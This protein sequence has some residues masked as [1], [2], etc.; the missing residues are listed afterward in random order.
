MWMHSLEPMDRAFRVCVPKRCKKVP[1]DSEASDEKLEMRR[2]IA[3][4][5]DLNGGD[6]SE[7]K[8]L[9]SNDLLHV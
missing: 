7:K 5:G 2:V 4:N 8:G 9:N 1:E 6:V 3:L